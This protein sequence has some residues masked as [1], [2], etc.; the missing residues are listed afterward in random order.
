MYSYINYKIEWQTWESCKSSEKGEKDT[1]LQLIVQ[2]FLRQKKIPVRMYKLCQL[3]V[4]SVVDWYRAQ[5]ERMLYVGREKKPWITNLP[6]GSLLPY[7]TQSYLLHYQRM[8]RMCVHFFPRFVERG[9]TRGGVMKK[10]GK[11]NVFS[12]HRL[13]I[14]KLRVYIFCSVRYDEHRSQVVKIA[15]IKLKMGALAFLLYI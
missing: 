4:V 5:P 12:F 6:V 13:C 9:G 10:R 7:N 1:W 3:Y 8:G 11:K 14:R 2:Y 15:W